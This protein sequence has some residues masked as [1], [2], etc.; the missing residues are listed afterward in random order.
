LEIEGLAKRY[1]GGVEALRGVSLTV[2]Q[3]QLV[4]LLGPNGAGKSTL[5]KICCGLVRPS[6]G[7]ATIAGAPAGSKAARA[8]LGYLAELFRFPGWARADEVLQL[9]QRLTGSD[10][11]ERDELLELVGLADARDRRVEAMSKGMQQR[12]G[13]AQALVNR[14]ALLLL[15]E[16]TSALDPVGRRVVRELLVELRRRGQSVL[17]NSHLL[18]EVELVCDHVAIV[19]HG[20]VVAA[21]TPEELTRPRG[22]EV[23]TAAGL[24]VFEGA[25]RDRVPGIV[26][27]LVA[28]GEEVFGVRLLRS[29]LEDVYVEAVT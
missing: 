20:R 11:G 25:G 4:G 12:L 23:D 5:V 28:G 26:A 24:R 17:L 2:E 13:I 9:H 7:T 10:G 3:G 19:D 8:H 15:D 27:D 22:V 18:S 16:P 21:G 1:R 29:T 6:S 14:P